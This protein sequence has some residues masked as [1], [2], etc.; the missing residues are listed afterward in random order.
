MPRGVSIESRSECGS[1][2][3][4]VARGVLKPPAEIGTSPAA[5][6]QPIARM[7]EGAA[8]KTAWK[9]IPV[10]TLVTIACASAVHRDAAPREAVVDEDDSAECSLSIA[11]RSSV[12]AVRS[13]L[14]AVADGS[15]DPCSGALA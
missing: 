1:T 4:C 6:S 13:A 2:P 9:L 10:L 7:L 3:I 15:L 12:E 11:P 8:M 5:Y 14:Q